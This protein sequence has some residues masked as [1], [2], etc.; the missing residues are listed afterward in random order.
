[1]SN[2]RVLAARQELESEASEQVEQVLEFLLTTLAARK[3][4]SEASTP[5]ERAGLARELSS[6]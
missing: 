6:A 1:M 5:Q 4:K 2:R 3:R